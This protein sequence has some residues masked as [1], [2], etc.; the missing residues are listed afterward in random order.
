MLTHKSLISEYVSVII[1]GKMEERD[2]MIH[3]LPLYH[4][5]QL[6]VFLGPG[7]YLGCTN[8]ILSA[9]K[10]EAIFDAVEKDGAT[11]LFCPPTV[12]IA[13]LRHPSFDERIYRI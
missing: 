8:I 5:A 13:L 2:V 6:H 7:V 10:P 11:Q 4:C 3:A 1:D 9:P 12:W